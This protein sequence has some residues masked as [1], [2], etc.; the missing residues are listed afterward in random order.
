MVNYV[1]DIDT[2]KNN[3]LGII[4]VAVVSGLI[5]AVDYLI[6]NCDNDKGGNDKNV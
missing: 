6:E 3:I 5:S 2:D 1:K 4:V